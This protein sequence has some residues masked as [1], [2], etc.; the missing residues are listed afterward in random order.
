MSS[1]HEPGAVAECR[2]YVAVALGMAD[3]DQAAASDADEV[4]ALRLA[5]DSTLGLLGDLGYAITPDSVEA[6]RQRDEEYEAHMGRTRTAFS[7]NS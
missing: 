7:P 6:E 3:N 4:S 5:L 1:P 2:M